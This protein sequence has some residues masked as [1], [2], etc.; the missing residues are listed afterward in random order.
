MDTL[1]MPL[2]NPESLQTQG[3]PAK[4]APEAR[5][6]PFDK[7]SITGN[8]LLF[9]LPAERRKLKPPH[10]FFTPPPPSVLRPLDGRWMLI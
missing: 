2:I 4:K 6:E 9:R 5:R 10:G 8:H 3:G 7:L 1:W